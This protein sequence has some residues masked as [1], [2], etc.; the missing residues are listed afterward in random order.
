[1]GPGFSP[2]K[3]EQKLPISSRSGYLPSLIA[4]LIA[5]P[6]GD[7][8]RFSLNPSYRSAGLKH[9]SEFHKREEQTAEW[10][11]HSVVCILDIGDRGP[12]IP[13]DFVAHRYYFS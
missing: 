9:L 3:R 11:Q 4:K 12:S 1:M 7:G 6:A 13:V 10:V 8:F 2:G 5:T